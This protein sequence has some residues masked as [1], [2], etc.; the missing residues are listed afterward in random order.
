[1]KYTPGPWEAYCRPELE[2]RYQ[3]SSEQGG[4]IGFMNKEQDALLA[5]TAPELLEALESAL[6]TLFNQCGLEHDCELITDIRAAI[7]KARGK[8]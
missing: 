3:I 2:C 6:D 7:A 4:V 1:M 5:A 8:S